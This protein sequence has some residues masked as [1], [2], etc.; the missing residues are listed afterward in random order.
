ML[1]GAASAS[2]LLS[3]LL[4]ANID[5]EITDGKNAAIVVLAAI[6]YQTFTHKN[7]LHLYKVFL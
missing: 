6:K 7:T 2:I 3:A 4:G 5:F 1:T